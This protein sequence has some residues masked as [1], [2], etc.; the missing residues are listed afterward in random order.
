MSDHIQEKKERTQTL[1][2]QEMRQAVNM[3]KV[4]EGYDA[5]FY[6]VSKTTEEVS[7]IDDVLS[8]QSINELEL[9]EDQQNSLKNVRGR[10]VSHLLLNS[11]KFSGDSKEMKKVK[12]K[13]AFLEA[14]I[15]EVVSSAN[16]VNIEQAFQEAIDAME[17]YKSAK[18]P[19]FATGKERMKKVVAQLSQT[20]EEYRMYKVG[21]AA[22]DAELATR[23]TG[24]SVLDLIAIGRSMC[25][26]SGLALSDDRD[27]TNDVIASVKSIR[28]TMQLK[29][30]HDTAQKKYTDSSDA[31]SSKIDKATS[32]QDRSAMDRTIKRMIHATTNQNKIDNDNALDMYRSLS[33][34]F[35]SCS[36]EEKAEKIAYLESFFEAILSF[37]M[38]QLDFSSLSDLYS[39]RYLSNYIMVAAGHDCEEYIKQYRA[40]LDEDDTSM[41]ALNKELF[42]EVIVRRE[43]LEAASNWF[44]IL[45]LILQ[46][47][48]TEKKIKINDLIKMSQDEHIQGMAGAEN[49]RSIHG[50]LLTMKGMLGDGEGGFLYGPGKSIAGILSNERKKRKLSDQDQSG[51]ALNAISA[52]R[53]EIKR[54]AEEERQRKLEEERKRKK[55]EEEKRRQEEEVKRLEEEKKRQEEEEKRKAEEE[56]KEAFDKAVTELAQSDY[57]AKMAKYQEELEFY[58]QESEKLKS[59]YMR[60][61]NSNVDLCAIYSMGERYDQSKEIFKKQGSEKFIGKDLLEIVDDE[62]LN[63]FKVD[64]DNE[65]EELGQ[66]LESILR[67]GDDVSMDVYLETRDRLMEKYRGRILDKFAGKH[68]ENTMRDKFEVENLRTNFINS[69]SF[70]TQQQMLD[71]HMLKNTIR[72]FRDSYKSYKDKIGRDNHVAMNSDQLQI[73]I[74]DYLDTVDCPI[75]KDKAEEIQNLMRKEKKSVGYVKSD[76]LF[77]IIDQIEPIIEEAEA[78]KFE[79]YKIA[80]LKSS[81]LML[82][83]RIEQ[84]LFRSIFKWVDHED[85]YYVL[86]PKAMTDI[87]GQSDL[88]VPQKPDYEKILQTLKGYSP[89]F[90]KH[91][92]TIRE[93][94]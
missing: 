2:N 22:C 26:N 12:D 79:E 16:A 66:A 49:M 46:A 40:L 20:K 4:K 18:N 48:E 50:S 59:E 63:E 27:Y 64:F 56:A 31:L 82:E 74:R 14:T 28:A 34:N 21:K 23:N 69:G 76:T 8:E 89:A 65:N 61:V 67:G 5:D 55:E 57:N 53:E 72:N 37:D 75:D 47:A 9:S 25:A 84:L 91:M 52:K 24:N 13:V 43:A 15:R 6:S 45:D 42:E 51:N 30:Q 68:L 1:L 93:M 44:A 7:F 81:N 92:M 73:R 29:E 80:L 58:N 70:M 17:A 62:M 39:E 88:Y 3:N 60:V 77:S 78:E 90:I 94:R 54:K 41:L 19:W 38:T 35:D 85:R 83:E 71:I 32:I 11:Q 10:N 87:P 86:R 36:S 33:K